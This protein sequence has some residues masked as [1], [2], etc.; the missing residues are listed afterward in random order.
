MQHLQ[1]S[2][3]VQKYLS[4]INQHEGATHEATLQPVY[5]YHQPD[6]MD[7]YTEVDHGTVKLGRWSLFHY[8]KHVYRW[9]KRKIYGLTWSRHYIGLRLGLSWFHIRVPRFHKKQCRT[10]YNIESLGLRGMNGREARQALLS[11]IEER[12]VTL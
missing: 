12:G 7:N 4:A 2:L 10:I 1:P 8:S 11:Y 5:Y 6:Y 3:K 9:G